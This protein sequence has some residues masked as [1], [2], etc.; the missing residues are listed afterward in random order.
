M[1]KYGIDMEDGFADGSKTRR[2]DP[3][4][5]ERIMGGG[6]RTGGIFT[7]RE[8]NRKKVRPAPVMH[9]PKSGRSRLLLPRHPSISSHIPCTLVRLLFDRFVLTGRKMRDKLV[10]LVKFID[11]R[12]RGL[13]LLFTVSPEVIRGAACLA[14]FL[15]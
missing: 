13:K 15:S 8:K 9:T 3:K 14:S 1:R 7:W 5:I 11:S 6:D 4:E 12:R 10:Q 2:L